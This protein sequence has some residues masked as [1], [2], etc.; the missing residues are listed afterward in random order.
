MCNTNLSFHSIIVFKGV[1]LPI[2]I[3][4]N[5]ISYTTSP[6]QFI[7]D[8]PQAKLIDLA[9]KGALNILKPSPKAPSLK[10]V[11]STSSLATI[12]FGAAI[13]MFGDML[14][15]ESHIMLSGYWGLVSKEVNMRRSEKGSDVVADKIVVVVKASKEIPKIACGLACTNFKD[16]K[17]EAAGAI[18]VPRQQVPDDAMSNKLAKFEL[19]EK[20]RLEETIQMQN[21][22]RAEGN[23]EGRKVAT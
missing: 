19:D 21:Y 14:D 20:N 10:R 18:E 11:G 6:V 4:Y 2:H 7:L 23:V 22:Y 3:T 16:Y 17:R 5:G 8:D 13:L 12:A 9:V 1:R 15:G